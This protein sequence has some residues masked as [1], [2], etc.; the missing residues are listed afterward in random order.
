MRSST[1]PGSSDASQILQRII[2]GGIGGVIC[3]GN[4]DNDRDLHLLNGYMQPRLHGQ[5]LRGAQEV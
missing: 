5:L 1:L 3:L 4:S 2:M